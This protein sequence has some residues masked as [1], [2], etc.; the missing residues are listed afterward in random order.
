MGYYSRTPD[1]NLPT[2]KVELWVRDN[3]AFTLNDPVLGRL[4][5]GNFLEGDGSQFEDVHCEVTTC[6]WRRGSTSSTDFLEPSAG[7]ATITLYDPDRIYDPA[8]TDSPKISK[9]RVG[10]PVRISAS[11]NGKDYVQYTGFLWS[12][13]WQNDIATFTATDLFAKLAR[14]TLPAGTSLPA[15]QTAALRIADLLAAAGYST[16]LTLALPGTGRAMNQN[17]GSTNA[18]AA[19][20]KTVASDWGLLNLQPNGNL[21]YANAWYESLRVTW[22]ALPDSLCDAL[23]SATLPGIAFDRVRNDISVTSTNTAISTRVSDADSIDLYG[24]TSWS[25]ET[26]LQ[27]STDLTW[28]ANLAL[29]WYKQIPNRVPLNVVLDPKASAEAAAQLWPSLLS[30]GLGKVVNLSDVQG[31]NV[32]ALAVG[33]THNYDAAS[34]SW[35]VFITCA[36]HPLNYAVNTF[37]VNGGTLGYLDYSN[38]LKA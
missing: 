31:I 27:N 22:F 12:L 32:N 4:N 19:I 38:V 20:A 26:A 34:D 15:G 29:L 33:V 16:P 9:L 18:L 1:P 8:N 11:W 35:Q 10:T 25:Y 13:E 36:A 28:W 17:F 37:T 3:D 24:R 2:L 7:Y 21:T 23:S 30:D 6:S 14:A 5:A